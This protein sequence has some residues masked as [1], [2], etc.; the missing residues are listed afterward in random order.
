MLYFL[1]P[2][3]ASRHSLLRARGV[4]GHS[5]RWPAALLLLVLALSACT[6]GPKEIKNPYGKYRTNIEQMMPIPYTPRDDGLSLSPAELHAFKTVSDLDRDL[7]EE[8]ART[9]ELHF[10]Y[11]VHER[12]ELFGR[13]LERSA[14]FLPHVRKTFAER[15]IPEDIAYLFMVESGGNPNARSR[16]GALGLWQFMPYT[17]KHYRLTQNSWIDE[18]RDPYKATHAA[19]DYLLKLYNDF[20]NWHL[21]VAAYNAG[22]GK[23]GRAVNGTGANDFFEL[24]RLDSKLAVNARLKDE[25]RDYVPKLIAV[26]KI[27]RNLERLGFPQPAPDMA[28]NLAPMTI[29]SGTNLS[30]LAQNLGLTWDEFSGMNPAFRR[31]ASPPTTESTAYVPLDRRA[32]AERWVAGAEARIYA[33]WKEYTVKKGDTL[34]SIAK[35]HKTT[36][37][38]LKQANNIS[39][40]PSRGKSILIPGAGRVEPV[41]AALPQT[42]T[43]S[44]ASAGTYTVQPGDTLYGLARQWGTSVNSLREANRMGSKQTELAAGQRISVPGDSMY[45]PGIMPASKDTHRSGVTYMVRRGDTVSSIAL[46]T[47][48][49]VRDLC[50]INKLNS[51]KPAVRTGQKLIIPPRS[52]A[53]ALENASA[54][55]AIQKR[56]VKVAPGDT[57]YGLAQKH[58]VSLNTLREANKLGSNDGLAVGQKIVIPGGK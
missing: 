5:A 26:A 18:R 25:T 22:E 13:Y 49:S 40:L 42:R 32:E 45:K 17:G 24:C 56:T 36:E 15:G 2:N 31:T 4:S 6:T 34:A 58:N 41:Y 33:G 55:D 52:P 11:F 1:F 44:A 39:S 28:W 21:A 8:D 57:L 43:S 19:A 14:R 27:M 46:K 54:E 35:R 9:V 12:R 48:V 53:A 3:S 47:G 20:S 30:A 51:A 16:V 10:K 38:A 37:A 23:I 7:S 50:T 29:P